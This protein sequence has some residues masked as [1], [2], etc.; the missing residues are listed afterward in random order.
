MKCTSA[1]R[2]NVEAELNLLLCFYV[3]NIEGVLAYDHFEDLPIE[4]GVRKLNIEARHGMAP[5]LKIVDFVDLSQKIKA[6][7]LQL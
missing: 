5:L 4:P 3:F 1:E 7:F 2:E 6:W